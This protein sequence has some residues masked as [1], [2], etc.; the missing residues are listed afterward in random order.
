MQNLKTNGPRP[1][2]VFLF[3]ILLITGAYYLSAKLGLQFAFLKGNVTLIW[4]PSGIGLAAILLMGPGAIPG[5][6]LGA[7]SATYSTGASFF[8]SLV[9]AIGNP[10]AA[11]VPFFLIKRFGPFR[12]QLDDLKSVL[13]LLLYGAL[14]G[15]LFSATIGSAG[16][17]LSNMGIWSNILETW[18]KWWLGDA[19]GVIVFSPLLL[20]WLSQSISKF[21]K[22]RILEGSLIFGLILLVEHL[23]F[24]G[25]FH[26]EIAYSLSY[27]VFPLKIWAAMRLDSR[28]VSAINLAAVSISVWGTVNGY[29]PFINSTLQSSLIFLSSTITIFIT[30][31]ILSAA[32]TERRVLADRL[33]NQSN[34]D[35]LTGLYNR[36]YFD[37]ET[38]RLN[39]SR[40]YPIS[41]I[42][43][44]VDNLKRVNDKHGHEKGDQILINIAEVFNKVFRKEDIVSRLGGDEFAVLLP[45]TNLNSLKRIVKRFNTEVSL[46]NR[47]HPE[48]PIQ[49]SL[50]FCRA[51]KNNKIEE[52]LKKADK[53]MYLEKQKKHKTK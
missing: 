23:V 51:H 30:T 45:E 26:S 11:I 31:L 33:T 29:G 32:V 38:K 2:I 25:K 39:N 46:F 34:H 28:G 49:I 15:P 20:T 36:L 5:I 14:V 18:F 16:I 9:T 41:V 1:V 6:M 13:S 12:P 27:L 7:F 37:E 35:H 3:K 8:F 53:L 24:G 10:L 42:M 4:P 40:Q 19:M 22:I 21:R 47:A 17:L 50:G 44:D 48:L 52:C 43:T